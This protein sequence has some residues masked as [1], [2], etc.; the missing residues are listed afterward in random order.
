MIFFK[1]VLT[2]AKS[3]DTV[4]S[5]TLSPSAFLSLTPQPR[6]FLSQGAGDVPARRL[7]GTPWLYLIIAEGSLPYLGFG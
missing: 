4:Q 6:G 7:Q 3:N 2:T 1:Q 5:T